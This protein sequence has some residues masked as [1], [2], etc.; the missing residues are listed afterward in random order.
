MGRTTS[1][2][3]AALSTLSRRRM[4]ESLASVSLGV[5]GN[6]S[7]SQPDATHDALG[8]HV[9]SLCAA[10]GPL[11]KAWFTSREQVA[12]HC[13]SGA[14]ALVGLRLDRGTDCPFTASASDAPSWCGDVVGVWAWRGWGGRHV[15]VIG[16]ADRVSQFSSVFDVRQL[17]FPSGLVLSSDSVGTLWHSSL[18]R[19]WASGPVVVVVGV[20]SLLMLVGCAAS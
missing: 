15:I 8:V 2:A 6:N 19:Y 14:L 7:W 3:A 12:A 4:T 9:G 1:A 20:S 10:V 16:A 13:A 18:R 11:L 5:L 17:A